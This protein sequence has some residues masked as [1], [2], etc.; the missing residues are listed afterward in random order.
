MD[1][2]YPPSR[3][4]IWQ[5]S[6]TM[7]TT[8]I[9]VPRGIGAERSVNLMV[10]NVPGDLFAIRSD[11]KWAAVTV[12]PDTGAAEVT[13]SLKMKPTQRNAKKKNGVKCQSQP[14]T[15]IRV[16]LI[17]A[18]LVTGAERRDWSK[19]CRNENVWGS[20]IVWTTTGKRMKTVP[21]GTGVRR[22]ETR[23]S[24]RQRRTT[25]DV[26]FYARR[27]RYLNMNDKRGIVLGRYKFGNCFNELLKSLHYF[28]LSN[29]MSTVNKIVLICE[30]TWFELTGV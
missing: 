5:K 21:Q 4:P 23:F 18:H 6:K 24:S 14:P 29:C 11:R 27:R 15:M 8:K 19:S 26:D 13:L 17:D 9:D 1:Y 25:A 30:I 12:H 7:Q 20:L 3:V 22:R 2:F 16:L 28:R 10:Q